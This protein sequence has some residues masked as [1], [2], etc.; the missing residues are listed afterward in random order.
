MQRALWAENIRDDLRALSDEA[1]QIESFS[2]RMRDVDSHPGEMIA[3]IWNDDR[4]E[5]VVREVPKG[6]L[7][8]AGLMLIDAINRL[9]EKMNFDW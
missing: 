6:D 3:T 7:H 1:Y 8:E 9:R 4:L 5:S 2:G